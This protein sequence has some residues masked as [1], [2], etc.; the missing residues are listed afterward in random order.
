NQSAVAVGGSSVCYDMAGHG[1]AG[2]TVKEWVLTERAFDALLIALD[3]D[4]EVA[5]GKYE[6]MRVKLV[7]YFECRGCITSTDE[8][9]RTINVVARKID[10]GLTIQGAELC[11]YFFGVARIVLKEYWA[12]AQKA[13]SSLEVLSPS[14]HPFD[15]PHELSERGMEDRET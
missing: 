11:K 5:G 12:T 14:D 15:D 9:D 10:E 13:P 4:R 7:K 6:Q 1:E 3:C 2:V 8:A